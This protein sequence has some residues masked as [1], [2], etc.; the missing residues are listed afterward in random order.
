M[1]P[2]YIDQDMPAY[3]STNEVKS[4]NE[5]PEQDGIICSTKP[6]YMDQ[7]MPAYMS[8]TEVKNQK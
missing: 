3:M 1:E 5:L 4:R 8:T 2:G 6:G 7:D